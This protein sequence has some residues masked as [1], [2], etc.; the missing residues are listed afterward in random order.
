MI[1][2]V[3]ATRTMHLTCAKNTQAQGDLLEEAGQAA[4][5]VEEGSEGGLAACATLWDHSA[6]SLGLTLKANCQSMLQHALRQP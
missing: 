4:E 2:S 3:P 5:R 1:A 6:A